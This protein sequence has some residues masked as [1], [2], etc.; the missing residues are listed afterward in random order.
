MDTSK[1]HDILSWDLSPLQ[2]G[3]ARFA[4]SSDDSQTLPLI[5]RVITDTFLTRGSEEEAEAFLWDLWEFLIK[6]GQY[7]PESRNTP[8]LSI[9][10]ALYAENQG[11]IK[12]W[13]VG[14]SP[15]TIRQ[16]LT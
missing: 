3:V 15:R 4:L 7:L 2:S 12:I 5:V 16:G 8:L 1:L 14:T 13:G 9:V 11:Q 6:L 10:K